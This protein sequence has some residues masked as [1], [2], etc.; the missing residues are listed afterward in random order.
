MHGWML[1]VML[2][3]MA[4]SELWFDDGKGDFRGCKWLHMVMFTRF[5]HTQ[6]H[7]IINV[8]LYHST[9]RGA[10]VLTASSEFV[11]DVC[12]VVLMLLKDRHE[13]CP[14][15]ILKIDFRFEHVVECV[16]RRWSHWRLWNIDLS[17]GRSISG[18]VSD[19]YGC[20]L[21]SVKSILKNKFWI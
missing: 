21:N 17:S 20:G 10:V 14:S 19:M 7:T 16:F 13:T 1:L 18:G 15:Q 12:K 8:W 5:F 6:D 2:I 3:N 4:S 11:Y 9:R